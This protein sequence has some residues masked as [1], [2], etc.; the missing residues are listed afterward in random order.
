MSI[1]VIRQ[2]PGLLLV[3]TLSVS[4]V[5]LV[6]VVV[7]VIT[8]GSTTGPA[9][10]L[11]IVA[12]VLMATISMVG[13][14]VVTHRVMAHLEGER[15]S[16]RQSF[17]AVLPKLPTLVAWASISLTLGAVIRSFERGRGLL[18][19]LAR[20]VALF[21]IVA[22]SAIT[23]FVL[24]VILF[25]NRTTIEAIKRSRELVRTSWGEGVVGVGALNLLFSL[26][27]LAVMVLAILL[28]IAQLA[29]LAVLLIL[30]A[31]VGFNLLTAVASPVFTVALYRYAMTG[32]VVLGF[33]EQDL[34]SAFRPRRRLATSQGSM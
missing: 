30:A 4:A 21:V 22:W 2:L 24:P 8:G 33:S 9:L 13:Q 17:E 7:A 25:E 11:W 3:P 1:E 23:F 15:S 20:I 19:I 26:G 16:N 14:A 34:A 18:G 32:Q 31:I 29:I 10:L 5:A 6:F 12:F 27:F 28:S